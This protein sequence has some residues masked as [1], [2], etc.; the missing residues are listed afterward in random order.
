MII[1]INVPNET[2]KLQYATIDE[3]GYEEWKTVTFGEIV[4]VQAD[5]AEG[6]VE[7]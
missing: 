7:T 3:N 6:G 5:H 1:T 4:S 2:V